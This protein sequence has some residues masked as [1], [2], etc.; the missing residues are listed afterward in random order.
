MSDNPLSTSEQLNVLFVP[1][2][3]T[4]AAITYGPLLG[5][6]NH[7][8]EPVVKDLEVYAADEPPANYELDLEVEGIGRAADHAG[9]DGFHLVAYS[10]GAGIAL[11]F[12]AQYP[13]RL[14]SLALIE[15]AWIGNEDWSAEDRADWAAL[16]Q[17]MT[18]PNEERMNAFIRWHMRPGVEPPKPQLPPGP[19]PPWMAK[20]P[21]GLEALSQ[22]FRSYRLDRARLCLLRGPVYYAVGSLSR[23]FFERNGKTLASCFL[24]FRMEVYKGRSHFDP[25]HRAEPERFAQALLELWA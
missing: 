25:P 6:L 4:P 9:F 23:E 8:L 2:A 12:T 11:A 24:D 1:G 20:R 10:G 3:V 17:L 14:K 7:R 22:A 21:A 19:P 15:P 5:V 18:L 16:D 13:D